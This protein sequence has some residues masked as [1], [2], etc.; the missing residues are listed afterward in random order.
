PPM[1]LGLPFGWLGDAREDLQQRALAGAV[2]A[3]DAD[4]LAGAHLEGDIA[5]RPERRS[6]C[7]R[8]AGADG[9]AQSAERAERQRRESVAERTMPWPRAEPILFAQAMATNRDV[10]PHR[11]HHVGKRALHPLEVPERACEDDER[12]RR[13]HDEQGAGRLAVTEERP[14]E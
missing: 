3:D 9:G 13:R 4:D 12:D 7:R 2:G 10:A 5:Q 11:L 14:S 6:L 1:N 8:S